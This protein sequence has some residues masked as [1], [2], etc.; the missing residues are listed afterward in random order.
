M[1]ETIAALPDSGTASGDSR[2][3]AS[4][5]L[6]SDCNTAALVGTRRLDRLALP[7]AL[8][9]PGR[10]RPH[11]R[12]RGRPLVDPA[13]WRVHQR[14]P[15]P[16]GLARHRDDVHDDDRHR[17]TDRRTRLRRRT[18]RPRPRPRRAARAAALGRGRRRGRSSCDGARAAPRVRARAPA[19]PC[20]PRTA[21]ARSAARTRSSSA[22][23]VPDG[24]STAARCAPRSRSPR[25]TRS[26]SRCAGRPPRAPATSR[27][28]PD[29]V[30]ARIADTA[31]G[32]RSWESEH[33]VY[34]GPH[35]E[36]V[37]LSSRVLKG[38]TYRP[39]GAIVAAPT[40]S[41][42]ETVGGERNWD[43]RY[44][45]IRDASLTLQALY[46]GVL[47]RRGRELRLVHD[48]LGRRRL[49]APTTRC[50]SCTASAASTTSPSASSPHLRGWRDSAPVRVGNGAWN[51]TQLDVYGELLDAIHL[52]HERLG[53]LHPEIQ[54][55]VAELAD[56]AARPVGGEGR[57]HVGDA[58][59]AAAPPLLE[60]AVLDGARPRGEAGAAPR[61]AREGR[62]VD[63]RARP[64]PRG[65]PRARLERGQAGVRAVVRLRRA[66]RRPAADAARRL[67]AGDRRAHALDHRGDRRRAHARTG[68]CCATATTR[69]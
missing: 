33:D 57:G 37:R 67:P 36:L 7:A 51:Q 41:L 10:V 59:R 5:G 4:Y 32:W 15:L 19:V 64:H 60:G 14:A 35:R 62:R 55:F 23:A 34:E 66:R 38:L 63:G 21:A 58:R 43:Y 42:P 24:R 3:I 28:P 27:P 11:P 61:R 65:D 6:L 56:A 44:S 17:A 46:I 26:A 68:S 45:W 30:A 54:R 20:R 25:A 29:A 69:A 53:E 22:P 2:P 48:E 52:Y 50:R 16:A 1:T 47:L 40:T 9:R 12:P 18:A 13:G 31:E 8:R 39:T 49:R